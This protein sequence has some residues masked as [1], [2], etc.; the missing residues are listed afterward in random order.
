MKDAFLYRA[1]IGLNKNSIP[2]SEIVDDALP[3][4]LAVRRFASYLNSPE[5]KFVFENTTKRFKPI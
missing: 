2:L 3:A 1:Y 5:E 4:L